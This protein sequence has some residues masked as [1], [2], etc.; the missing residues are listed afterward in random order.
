MSEI[1]IPIRGDIGGPGLT[2]SDFANA[3]ADVGDNDVRLL[4]ASDGG[5]VFT[6]LS[7]ISQLSKIEGR[8]IVEVES[9]MASAA[10]FFA[11]VADRVE[12][13]PH[14]MAMA[15]EATAGTIGSHS[16]MAKMASVLQMIDRDI[17]SLYARRSFTSQADWLKLMAHEFWATA[18]EAVAIGLADVVLPARSGGV[19]A[20]R[21]VPAAAM[22]RT[23]EQRA[24]LNRM[25][26]TRNSVTGRDLSTRAAL[27]SYSVR[28]NEIIRDMAADER[29]VNRSRIVANAKG[30]KG[31]AARFLA[32]S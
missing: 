13:H 11:A 24:I 9:L 7:C 21:A 19:A 22:K 2:E 5:S 3:L 4:I 16:D 31:R 20:R 32:W 1:E 14:A 18:D 6:A 17:A 29:K 26:N 8:V 15:H 12:M 27:A 23:D 10:T 30:D 25:K 28:M